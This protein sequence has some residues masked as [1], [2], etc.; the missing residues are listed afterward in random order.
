MRKTIVSEEVCNKCNHVTQRHEYEL[1]CDNCDEKL[2]H[3]TNDEHGFLSINIF[4]QDPDELSEDMEFCSWKC[5]LERLKTIDCN[6]FITLPHL[7]YDEQKKG[8]R[9]KD[10]L[11]LIKE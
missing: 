6:Y 11:K 9:A 8:F 5:C 3:H 10:F 7:L 2:S 1:Y 4:S